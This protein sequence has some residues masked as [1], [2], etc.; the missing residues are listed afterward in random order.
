MAEGD[1][2]ALATVTSGHAPTPD[3]ATQLVQS[4]SGGDGGLIAQ[5]TTN[6]FFTA[7]R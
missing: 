5:L 7:V 3:L 1:R 6:P 2:N 4:N